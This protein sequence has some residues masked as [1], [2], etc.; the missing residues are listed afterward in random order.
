MADGKHLKLN[1][2]V[3]W[4]EM[5]KKRKKHKIFEM[6]LMNRSTTLNKIKNS[7]CSLVA[8]RIMSSY[9]NIF[10]FFSFFTQKIGI[11]G[12][13][14]DGSATLSF[15]CCC[16]LLVGGDLHAAAAVAAYYL[17]N[18]SSHSQQ[19]NECIRIYYLIEWLNGLRIAKMVVSFQCF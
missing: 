10:V 15:I 13:I 17:I 9:L 11:V 6:H 8:S 1:G 2:C 5:N 18:I 16:W 7:K 14:H 12:N 4:I 19:L 3:A